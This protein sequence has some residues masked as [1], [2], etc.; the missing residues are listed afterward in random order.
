MK[1]LW[2]IFGVLAALLVIL[3]A[4]LF[5]G[6]ARIKIRVK[7][8]VKVVFSV[9]GIRFWLYPM[10]YDAAENQAEA[11]WIKKNLAKRRQKKKKNQ[12]DRAAG[13]PVPNMLDNLQT[14]F[15]L[16]KQARDHVGGKLHITVHRFH[17]RVAASDAAQT[18]LLY[19]ATVG[20]TASIMQWIHTQIAP[21]ERHKKA[22]TVTP[23]YVTGQS[24]ADVDIALKMSLFHALIV[25]F[26]M[27]DAYREEQEKAIFRATRR[28]AAKQAREER[29]AAARAKREER[30]AAEQ[31]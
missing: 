1:T 22:I 4:V 3:L 13:K 16:I 31:A 23:D 28:L 9:G 18:A 17:L 24:D 29:R 2:I 10:K 25:I 30:A 19:G 5:L 21:I 11:R 14:V 27:Y 15:S 12:A 7:N 8:T 26:H 6:K 20:I